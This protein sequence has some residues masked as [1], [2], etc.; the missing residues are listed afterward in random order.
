MKFFYSGNTTF[1]PAGGDAW[2][3]T[4]RCSNYSNSLKASRANARV[5]DS[6]NKIVA[7]LRTEPQ[8][9]INKQKLKKETRP[10]GWY[11]R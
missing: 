3:R 5:L 2:E 9:E 8:H 1:S 11:T 10:L 6:T 4:R 7:K